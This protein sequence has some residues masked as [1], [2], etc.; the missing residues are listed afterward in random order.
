MSKGRKVKAQLPLTEVNITG[1]VLAIF[2]T[3]GEVFVIVRNFK[4]GQC[5]LIPSDQYSI[6]KNLSGG[7]I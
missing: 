5:K 4:G 3:W 6:S 7:G 2:E 1:E